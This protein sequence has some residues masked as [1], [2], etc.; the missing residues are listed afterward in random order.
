M[1]GFKEAGIHLNVLSWDRVGD[2]GKAYISFS[3]VG[4]GG[5]DKGAG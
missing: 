5:I 3:P 1:G 4:E 2:T